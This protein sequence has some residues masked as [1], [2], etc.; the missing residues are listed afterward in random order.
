MGFASPSVIEGPLGRLLTDPWGAIQ[1][2]LTELWSWVQT[3]GPI[4][5][6]AIVLMATGSGLLRRWWYLRCQDALHER[7]RV[8]TI[9]APPRVDSDGAEAMWSN[10]VG[11]VRPMMQRLTTGQPHLAWEYVFGH[12]GVQ[13]RLWVPGVVPPGMVERAVEAAWPGAHT[14]TD[15]ASP[16]MPLAP[17]E[18]RRQLVTGGTLR[19]ARSE[20]LPIRSKFDADPIRA[21]LGAP[22]GLGVHDTACVQVLAPAGY[23]SSGQTG[24]SSRPPSQLRA[25]HPPGWPA[26]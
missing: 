3:W 5:A 13:I 2:V 10:L 6:P 22:V 25:V 16:P 11:L 17:A 21:L 14:R 23:R 7:S 9:L 26:A 4:T 12:D 15:E 24:S 19:L 8:I 20:A 1:S 18:G